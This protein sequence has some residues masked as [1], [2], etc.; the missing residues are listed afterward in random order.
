MDFNYYKLNNVLGSVYGG[1]QTCLLLKEELV[2]VMKPKLL[3]GKLVP[4]PVEI[5][6]V[7][8]DNADDRVDVPVDD[9]V[10]EIVKEVGVNLATKLLHDFNRVEMHTNPQQ[11]ET[12]MDTVG[13]IGVPY[14][15]VERDVTVK[16]VTG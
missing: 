11:T 15:I 12:E 5:D 16:E 10:A 9:V 1:F 3:V 7:V 2:Q 8:D 6:L 4:V 13:Y 14:R